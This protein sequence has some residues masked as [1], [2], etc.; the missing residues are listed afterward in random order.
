MNCSHSRASNM[1]TK[2][3]LAIRSRLSLIKTWCTRRMNELPTVGGGMFRYDLGHDLVAPTPHRLGYQCL[4]FARG[5]H[6]RKPGPPPATPGFAHEATSPAT[7][8]SAQVVLDRVAKALGWLEKAADSGYTQNR[9]W[10]ASRGVSPV[11][12][13]HLWG[14]Q[15]RR[16]EAG[17][18]EIRALIFRMAAENPTWGAPRIHGELLKLSV[19]QSFSFVMNLIPIHPK[20][21]GEHSLDQV[22]ADYRSLCDLATLRR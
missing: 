10:V 13:A 9:G 6:P 12:A 4:P 14:A 21:L 5:S 1:G 20:D 8:C 16:T 2:V 18:K 19:L 17:G 15:A 22:M 11:L 7:Q 3:R